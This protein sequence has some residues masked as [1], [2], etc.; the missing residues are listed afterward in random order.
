MSAESGL[1]FG[2]LG[3]SIGDVFIG[4][5]G[6]YPA[7]L[8]G[9]LVVLAAIGVFIAVSAVFDIIKLGNRSGANNLPGSTIAWK[10]IA[11]A[12]LIDLSFW[13]GVWAASLWGLS[14]PMDISQ[15]AASAGEDY[16]KTAIMAVLGFLVLVGYVTLG[17]AYIMTSQLGYLSPES[18]SSLIGSIIARLVSGSA[19]VAAMHI[20]KALDNSTGFNWIPQ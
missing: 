6:E 17:R 9:I 5:S 12:S 3:K 20:S 15:Y 18:R 2:K 19:L 16:T 4:L 14:N 11:G 7:I 10:F 1:D 13:T 8:K